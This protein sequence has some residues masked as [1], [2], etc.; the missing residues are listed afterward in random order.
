MC[1]WTTSAGR[2]STAGSLHE[3]SSCRG[4]LCVCVLVGEQA[5]G[6]EWRREWHKI[7]FT[8]LRWW[9]RFLCSDWDSFGGQGQD[10][11]SP[12]LYS[13]ALYFFPL[14]SVS[15][16]PVKVSL[17]LKALSM[18]RSRNSNSCSDG[19]ELYGIATRGSAIITSLLDRA[20]Y[21]IRHLQ[22][23]APRCTTFVRV[24]VGG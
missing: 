11:P 23:P 2:S 20:R 4:G 12:L 18:L 15:L 3:Q 16:F 5:R 6:K 22:T 21:C 1:G 8:G 24:V 19:G 17:S 7:E 14:H 13:S 10:A 9:A